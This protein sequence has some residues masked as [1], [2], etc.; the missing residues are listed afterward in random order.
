M[1]LLACVACTVLA[2][3]LRAQVGRV[4]IVGVNVVDV[5]TGA[6][7]PNRSILIDGERIVSVA[8]HDTLV[9]D[10]T[11]VNGRGKYVIPG[12][13]DM[14]SH[15]Q[16][17]GDAWLGLYLANGV[18][19]LRDMGADLDFI[20]PLRDA[21]ASGRALGPMIIAAGPILDNAPADWPFRL[22]VTN[23]ADGRE[24]VRL[25]KK[26]GVDLVKVH[27]LTPRDAFFAIAQEA[28]T[29]N[30][31]LAGHVPVNVL[32]EEAVEA[33][34]TSIE[35][36]SEFRLWKACSGG[37]D[38]RAD[39]CRP[40]FEL[41]ARRHVWQTPTLVAMSEIL[42]IGTSASTENADHL[43]YATKQVRNL[44][45]SNQGKDATP[46]I[47]AKVRHLADVSATV[48]S[49][50]AKLGVGI[51]AGCDAMIAGFCV[52]A[53]LQAMV[54]GGMT[55]I[56]AL[57]TATLNPVRYLHLEQTHGAVAANKIADL[58][59]LDG[60]PLDNIANVGRIS[61]VVVRGRLLERKE[62][63]ELLRRAKTAAALE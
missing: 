57:Q 23:A 34:I 25:L 31:P 56:S 45:A 14:H 7:L 24:A 61:A 32:T 3:Q 16:A 27:N 39:A 60:N 53:E 44:W 36:F 49:D 17:S 48:T 58:V 2:A 63:D 52:S 1:R 35:H 38:Y 51:L 6:I 54:R 11:V 55:P 41:L 22:R 50:M 47:I 43:A 4:A 46:E 20:L 9:S 33:G 13:W 62:L 18:T 15:L 42:A 10:A 26:R 59:I 29:Q 5:T 21:T 12:L 8:D 28:R 30:L 40:L 19:G 37:L